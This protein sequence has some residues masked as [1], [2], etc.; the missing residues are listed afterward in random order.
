MND[1][2]IYNYKGIITD[3]QHEFI[4]IKGVNLEDILSEYSIEDIVDALVDAD[5]DAGVIDELARRNEDE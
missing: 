5:K 1:L 2:T 4:T 3:T